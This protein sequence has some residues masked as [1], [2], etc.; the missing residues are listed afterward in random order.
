M[1]VMWLNSPY[2]F[3][4]DVK[5]SEWQYGHRA[6][7]LENPDRYRIV[8]DLNPELDLGPR[9]CG[10]CKKL[11]G[12]STVRTVVLRQT[13]RLRKILPGRNQDRAAQPSADRAVVIVYDK[14]GDKALLVHAACVAAGDR[15]VV[16]RRID[17]TIP[18]HSDCDFCKRP[19]RDPN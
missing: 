10:V 12:A 5:L 9:T 3:Y 17:P 6:C 4:H 1:G 19:L 14:K 8:R 11:L 15:Y 2:V 18:L 13:Q 16:K 7:V